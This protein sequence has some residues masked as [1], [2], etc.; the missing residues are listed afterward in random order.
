MHYTVAPWLTRESRVREE[1]CE[2]LLKALERAAGP[3]DLRHG[4]RQRFL[5][6]AAGE[7]GRPKGKVLAVDIQR[8]MLGLFAIVPAR[9]N[10]AT[11]SCST[12][13]WPTR[14][15]SRTHATWC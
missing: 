8:E 3:G 1:D 5:H 10:S 4:L 12:A 11:S 15:W 9:K 7:V 6:I 13:T 14:T 2:T